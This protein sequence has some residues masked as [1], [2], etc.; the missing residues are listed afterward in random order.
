MNDILL[1]IIVGLLLAYGIALPVI[2]IKLNNKIETVRNVEK[3]SVIKK[4]LNFD[5]DIKYLL[6]LVEYHCT[7]SKNNILIP[8]KENNR[9]FNII[10]DDVFKET[11]EST[12]IKIIKF[13][14]PEYRDT[15]EV[16]VGNTVDFTSELVYNKIL[17][18]ATEL[19]N[20]TIK[21]MKRGV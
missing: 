19:N 14:S 13:L 5:N 11:V 9:G 21:K 18:I 20:D 10:N 16:Y 17:Q 8:Y 6:F 15:I 2:F 4:N 7:N 12:V 3:K 1:I